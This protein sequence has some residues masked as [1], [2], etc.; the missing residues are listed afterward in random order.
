MKC[1]K[2]TKNAKCS[3]PLQNQC[4]DLIEELKKREEDNGDDKLLEKLMEIVLVLSYKYDREER[5]PR[6]KS[7]TERKTKTSK[8]RKTE[9]GIESDD[10]E[11]EQEEEKEDD[12][13]G[14][15]ILKD[16]ATYKTNNFLSLD[17]ADVDVIKKA[18]R[19]EE[20]IFDWMDYDY[21]F[22]NTFEVNAQSKDNCCICG[23]PKI[24]SHP[25]VMRC[26]HTQCHYCNTM[27]VMNGNIVCPVKNCCESMSLQD[28]LT[29]IK[30]IKNIVDHKHRY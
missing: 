6:F 26:E 3:V 13:G 9:D 2:R 12:E 30:I 4:L 1:V 17:G 29:R 25:P 16:K 5:L 15:K 7:L 14:R 23:R 10:E 24:E 28:L 27:R 8:K 19:F 21:I 11:E 22:Q 18:F 20:D